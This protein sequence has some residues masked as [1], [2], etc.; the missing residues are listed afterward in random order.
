MKRKTIATMLVAVTLAV[1]SSILNAGEAQDKAIN[2]STA[3]IKANPKDSS[4]YRKRADAYRES[5]KFE[6]AIADYTKCIQMGSKDAQTYFFRAV[7]YG[8]LNKH[9]DAITD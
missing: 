6:A 1:S 4:A 3:A 5:R 8:E 9:A 2:E 7:A